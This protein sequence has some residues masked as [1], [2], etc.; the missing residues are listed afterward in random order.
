[1]D[2]CFLKPSA[3]KKRL[4]HLREAVR[5]DPTYPSAQ[6]NLGA[7]FINRAVEAGERINEL[8]DQLRAQRGSL[9]QDEIRRRENEIDRIVD[10]RRG[11][12]GEAI[13]PLERALDYSS[14]ARFEVRGD[15]GVSFAGELTG[16]SV[17]DGGNLSRRVEGFT[18]QV[19]YIGEGSVAGTFRKRSGEGMLEVALMVGNDEIATQATEAPDGSITISENVGPVGFEGRTVE[20][21]CQALFSAYIQVGEQDKAQPLQDCAGFGDMQ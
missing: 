13:E 15:Y 4:T 21:I 18:P 11:Y 1:M 17:R 12:F 6:F 14:G 2:R 10:D 7:A 3:T 16:R 8:D 5:I 19:F 9:S 20:T